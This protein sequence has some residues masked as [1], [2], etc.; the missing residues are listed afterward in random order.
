MSRRIHGPRHLVELLHTV[1]EHHRE[2]DSLMKAHASQRKALGEMLKRPGV[3][4]LDVMRT[5][6]ALNHTAPTMSFIRRKP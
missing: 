2:Q 4:P 3:N 5:E 6:T 1:H